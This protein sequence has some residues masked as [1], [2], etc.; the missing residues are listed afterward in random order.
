MCKTAFELR[1]SDCSSDVCSSDLI[2]SAGSQL[3]VMI[4]NLPNANMLR[5]A[6]VTRAY[7][8]IETNADSQDVSSRGS[9]AKTTMATPRANNPGTNLQ[10][11][12]ASGREKVWSSVSVSVDATYLKNKQN[13]NTST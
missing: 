4:P 1:I 9:E 11:G 5:Q 8:V 10:I 7:A 2:A 12:S 3:S 6:R 13:K